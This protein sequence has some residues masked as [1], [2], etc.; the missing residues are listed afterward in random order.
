VGV[1]VIFLEVPFVHMR[2]L[3][4]GAVVAVLV[5]VLHMFVLV[6]DVRVG[7]RSAAVR[8]LVAVRCLGHLLLRPD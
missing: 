1:L 5:L 6:A 4:A 2:V 7:V 3:V 8:V